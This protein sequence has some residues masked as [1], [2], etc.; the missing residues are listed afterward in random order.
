MSDVGTPV[1]RFLRRRLAADPPHVRKLLRQKRVRFAP[2]PIGRP[3]G[4]RPPAPEATVL[5]FGDELGAPGVLDVL[6]GPTERRPPAP[7]KKLRPRVL[8]SDEDLAVVDKQSGLAMH[9]GPRHGSDTLLNGLIARYPELVELGEDRNWGL[10][11]R[12]DLETSGLVVVARTE[13]AHEGLVRQFKERKIEKHYLA[14]VKLSE[15]RLRIG[16]IKQQVVGKSAVTEIESVEPVAE[17]ADVALVRCRPITGRTHQI[18]VHL[19]LCGSPVLYDKRYGTGPDETTAK[20][21]LKRL[22]LHAAVL[23]FEHPRSGS[24]LRFERDMPRDLRHSWRRAKKLWAAESEPA[25]ESAGESDDASA[26]PN[27]P[28]AEDPTEAAKEERATP[29]AE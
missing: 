24:P 27:E 23:G 5:A 20:L 11:H 17:G 7:N 13:Q 29:P 26:A 14:L 28:T 6:P 2:T 10:V 8:F 18:R 9:P 22:A 19:A 25:G 12:L 15:K 16:S 21:Y 1:D 4:E 3:G